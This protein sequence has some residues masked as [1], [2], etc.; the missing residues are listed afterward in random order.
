MA[1]WN[2][3]GTY[4]RARDF[5]DDQAGAIKMLSANFDQEHDTIAAGMNNCLAKDG[6]NAMTGALNMG[7]Q[8]LQ[9]LAAGTAATHGANL[10]QMQGGAYRYATSGGAAN[11]QTLAL[12]PTLTTY[13]EGQMFVFKAGFTNT[14][15]TTMNID[16]IA[17][18]D[19]FIHGTALTGYEIFA[20]E[21][22][23]IVYDGTQF[24][25]IATSLLGGAKVWLDT[26]QSIANGAADAIS[27]TDEAYDDAAFWAIGNPTRITIAVAGRYRV[28]G[29]IR[30]GLAVGAGLLIGYFKLNGA[31][32]LQASYTYRAW[33]GH[34]VIHAYVLPVMYEGIFAAN[35]YLELFAS[36]GT[37][38]A[39]DVYGGAT[40]SD[41]A[42]ASIERIR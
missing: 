22:Y 8:K 28:Y 36:Q 19:I 42:W 29:G 25:L 11:V 16:T 32:V 14:A 1:G 17:A 2:G 33:A 20:G 34:A 3:T 30:W 26:S 6:Q 24:N 12:T 39:I 40:E 27:W 37:G 10:V 21:I 4:S 7:S 5:T 15:A 41:V 38:A 31:D 35:D 13:V 9:A 23:V 18:K